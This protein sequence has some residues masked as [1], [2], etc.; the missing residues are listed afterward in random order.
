M[1]RLI[2]QNSVNIHRHISK[3]SLN[4]SCGVLSSWRFSLKHTPRTQLILEI[5]GYYL[6]VIEIGILMSKARVS[7]LTPFAIQRQSEHVI[8]HELHTATTNRA[9]CQ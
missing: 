6:Q 4:K 3:N 5:M 8:D 2:A 1:T 7:V 9:V